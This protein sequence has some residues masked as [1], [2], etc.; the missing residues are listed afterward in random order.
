MFLASIVAEVG[1]D[2]GGGTEV[3]IGVAAT[4]TAPI[5][6]AGGEPSPTVMRITLTRTIS[7]DGDVG[8]NSKTGNEATCHVSPCYCCISVFLCIFN[9]RTVIR[10][11]LL[12]LCISCFE[13]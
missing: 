6:L 2:T 7:E 5:V 8:T 3:D 11:R 13:F 1:V 9:G 10:L 4:D 12:L